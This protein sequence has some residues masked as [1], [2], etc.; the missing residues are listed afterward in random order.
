MA[1]EADQPAHGLDE[2]TLA[3]AQRV[4]GHARAGRVEEL[5]ELLD[6]GLPPNLRNDK[7]DSLLMSVTKE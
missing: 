5:T 3:F 4:F 6:Q 1:G 2:E 7:G